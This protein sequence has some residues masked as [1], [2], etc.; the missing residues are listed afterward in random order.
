MQSNVIFLL[1]AT[2]MG[3]SAA[4]SQKT[5]LYG[6]YAGV[7]P[8]RVGGVVGAAVLG[9]GHAEGKQRRAVDNDALDCVEVL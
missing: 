2:I 7:T 4:S 3:T 8:R 6:V 1:V 9:G 5:P